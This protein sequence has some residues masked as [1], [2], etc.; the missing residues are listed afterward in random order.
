[1][2]FG[3]ALLAAP[4]LVLFLS[5]PEMI[6][7]LSIISLFFAFYQ[8]PKAYSLSDKRMLSFLIPSL[9]VGVFVG[10][11]VLRVVSRSFLEGVLLVVIVLGLLLITF[12][13]RIHLPASTSVLAGLI[14]GFFSG[15]VG[16]G[17]PVY[18]SYVDSQ[19]LSSHVSRATLIVLLSVVELFKLPLLFSYGFVSSSIVLTAFLSIPLIW[20]A[21]VLGN[22]TSNV[23]PQRVYHASVFT[24]LFIA[25][26][27]LVV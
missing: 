20:L 19:A 6:V 23:L 1:M 17:G 11:Y 26:A 18:A 8:A 10:V 7:L 16:V 13:S 4:F 2:G 24:L 22:K 12:R 14:G 21:M 5:F 25:A 15:S 3:S 27:L 9:F